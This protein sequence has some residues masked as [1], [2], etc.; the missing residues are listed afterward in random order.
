MRVVIHALIQSYYLQSMPKSHTFLIRAESNVVKVYTKFLQS[1]KV[2]TFPQFQI[3]IYNAFGIGI[4]EMIKG[5]QNF[6]RNLI[7]FIFVLF[8]MDVGIAHYPSSGSSETFSD[9]VPRK[10]FFKPVFLAI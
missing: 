2:Y 3:L 7:Y 8:F 5:G 1:Y 9:S 10:H 4:F 6:L